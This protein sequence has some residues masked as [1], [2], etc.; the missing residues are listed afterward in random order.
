MK[1]KIQNNVRGWLE[2]IHVTS[3]GLL[4]QA[5]TQFVPLA[6][7]D[8]QQGSKLSGIYAGGDLSAY[9]SKMF[10][11]A[12]SVGAIIAVVRLMWAGYL[13]MGA[14]IVGNKAKAKEIFS[15]AIIGLLLLLA[16]WLILLKINPQLLNISILNSIKNSQS[17][18]QQ[19]PAGTQAQGN[20][21]CSG[22]CSYCDQST[23]Q[24]IIPAN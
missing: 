10:A 19:A 4:F 13:Y 1:N 18:G 14:D 5:T 15:N 2:K 23:G 16:I 8:G 11:F 3:T 9:V 21:Q 20:Q 24:C 12:L 6:P 17:T 22:A 7:M